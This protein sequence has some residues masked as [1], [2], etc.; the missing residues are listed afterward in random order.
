[1]K[2]W[3]PMVGHRV[4]G[5][6]P[7]TVDSC[8]DVN[9]R[10]DSARTDKPQVLWLRFEHHSILRTSW[11]ARTSCG[12]ASARSRIGWPAPDPGRLVSVFG[13]LR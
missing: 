2:G 5:M 8:P 12:S 6:S 11:S 4:G 1:V 10:I 3:A 13:D 7:F 9:D